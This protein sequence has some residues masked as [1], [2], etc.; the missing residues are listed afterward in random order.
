MRPT[1]ITV[2]AGLV[3]ALRDGVYAEL[4]NVA[5]VVIQAT[6]TGGHLDHPERYD[7]QRARACAACALLDLIGW[8]GGERYA[9]LQVDLARHRVVLVAAFRG[10]RDDVADALEDVVTGRQT[11]T[12][13]RK[14][15]TERASQLQEFVAA[16]EAQAGDAA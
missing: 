1:L 2:P 6:Q 15:I 7:Q 3:E 12:G 11:D 16:L 14:A 13:K 8:A 9:E 10:A 4:R 5:E